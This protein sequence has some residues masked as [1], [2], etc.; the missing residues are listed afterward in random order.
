MIKCRRTQRDEEAGLSFGWRAGHSSTRRMGLAVVLSL[1][2]CGL[3]AILLRVEG[4]QERSELREAGRL[5]VLISGTESSRRWLEWVGRESPDIDRWEPAVEGTLQV[6]MRRFESAL[7]AQVKHEPLL[8]PV[9]DRPEQSKLPPIL[10]PVRPSLP[11]VARE[12]QRAAAQAEVEAH[13]LTEACSSLS[14]RWG[15]P[16]PTST[17]RSLIGDGNGDDLGALR[18]RELLGLERRFRVAVNERGFIETCQV[19]GGRESIL[20]AAI[21]RWLRA[22][23]L[24]SS[25]EA[26]VWGEIQVRV[27]G[28]SPDSKEVDD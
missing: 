9:V 27:R 23:R 2:V 10:D 17:V 13:V 1:V 12:M 25:R 22:Q 18:P 11:E 26:L 19:L 21:S 7:Q 8:H 14:G 20:D 16:P 5:T 6:R 28:R 4:S 15:D 24:K 3:G